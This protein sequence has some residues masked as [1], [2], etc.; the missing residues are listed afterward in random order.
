MIARNGCF[1][2]YNK[3]KMSNTEDYQRQKSESPRSP[4]NIKHDESQKEN[5]RTTKRRKTDNGEIATGQGRRASRSRSSSIS[6]VNSRRKSPTR[7]LNHLET[8]KS[9]ILF[10][11]SVP[12]DLDERDVD[13]LF[14]R[15]KGFVAVRKVRNLY[16][17]EFNSVDNS[18]IAMAKF[19]EYRFR[20]DDTP[21][22]IEY[23]IN[24][25]GKSK[26]RTEPVDRF[27]SARNRS[28]SPPRRSERSQRDVPQ[29]VE[30]YRGMAP[31]GMTPYQYPPRP[32]DHSQR[33]TL[34]VSNLPSDVTE[35]ELSII[36]RLIPHF[37]S[38]K[39]LRMIKRNDRN[40]CFVD[41]HEVSDA[42][43]AMDQLQGFR[44]DPRD[45][46]GIRIEFDKGE[47][48][49]SSNRRRSP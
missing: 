36:F 13:A 17:V 45:Q 7:K 47:K 4:K 35:R 40:I 46:S 8:K 29:H 27:I 42:V 37:G 20:K 2:F 48:S 19:Q 9:H 21:I 30:Y 1:F 15:Q 38:F 49:S 14:N 32:Q 24:T 5:D 31:H 41:Y 23:D 39:G 16:F 6:S 44:I 10:V 3:K 12:R 33:A 26:R 34:F 25:G 11:K 28:K 18:S 43:M 22:E